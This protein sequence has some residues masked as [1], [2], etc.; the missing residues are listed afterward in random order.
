MLRQSTLSSTPNGSVKLTQPQTAKPNMSDKKM[1]DKPTN[2]QIHAL[3]LKISEKL[4]GHTEKMNK[5]DTNVEKFGY[6]IERRPIAHDLVRPWSKPNNRADTTQTPNG[7][8]YPRTY[9]NPI[10][11]NPNTPKPK[12]YSTVLQTKTPVLPRSDM[13]TQRKKEQHITLIDN[14]T[15][16]TVK[17]IKIPTPKQGK[18]DLQIGLPL[19]I[20]ERRIVPRNVNPLTKSIWISPFHPTTTPEQLESHII[21]HTEIKDK[22]KFKCTKLVKKEQDVTKMSFVSFKIDVIPEAYDIVF[23][24]EIWPKRTEMREFVKMAPP[25]QTLGD[26]VPSNS[27]SLSDINADELDELKEQYGNEMVKEI[28]SMAN[29]NGTNNDVSKSS[30]A[31]N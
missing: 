3:L 31:K 26:F 12:S 5:I 14:S 18:K 24:E 11:Q 17:S 19:N 21:E 10:M 29:G 27:K 25:K 2:E 7:T 20:S 8:R 9:P 4:D 1:N 22:S 6:Q 28:M 30:P 15:A 16:T 23:N 13:P